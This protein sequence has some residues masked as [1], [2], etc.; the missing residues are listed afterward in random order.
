MSRASAFLAVAAGAVA[1]AC[2]DGV[3]TASGGD[4][5]PIVAA[6]EFVAG[7]D[8][9]LWSGRSS[10]EPLVVRVTDR[11]GAPVAD[12]VVRFRID[13]VGARLSQ[14]RALTGPDG[15]AETFLLDLT[16]GTARI[17]ASIADVEDIVELPVRPAP[18][19]IRF[20]GGTGE[21]GVPG[22]PHPDSLIQVEVLDTEGRPLP[23][24]EVWFTA[25]GELASYRDT[26]DAEGRTSTILRRT[27]FGAGP[28][29]VT[30]FILGFP[31]VTARTQRP[32]EPVARRVVVV[33]IDGLRGD[34]LERWVPPT[35][36]RL[37]RE[38]AGTARATSVVP[39]LTVPAHLSLMA[40]VPPE[41][42]GVFSDDLE[43]TRQMASLDPLFRLARDRGR[44]AVAFM[45]DRG[46]LAGFE[47]ALQCRQAFGLDSLSLTEPTGLQ[48]V[49][50][51]GPA[52]A[53]PE[54]ELAFVHIPDPDLAGHEHG[55]ESDEYGEAVLR[56][57]SALARG[58][59]AATSDSTL[60]IVVSDHGGGGA[61][62][63]F[64][65]GSAAPEDVRVPLLLDGSG[66][67]SGELG[68][69]SILDVAPTALWALGLV[70]P[71][72]Y[73][74]RVLLEAFRRNPAAAVG[75]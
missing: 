2:S 51:A 38:G 40:G 9:E 58:L 70:P 62:G 57:D 23:D 72:E 73:E 48:A 32:L 18:G 28:G 37:A 35:L 16:P 71:G 15:R 61:F 4:G 8:Q 6:V 74:G 56:A 55:F 10:P 36:Q 75:M 3:P 67:V 63:R 69:A 19:E 5:V 66:V 65:H 12:T 11:A 53:D 64:Q 42:H 45:S 25:P 41:E 33:S 14:G 1:A 44:R 59:E 26:T 7:T 60:V 31:G 29:P 30:A 49:E 17:R 68:E 47:E 22:F 20:L 39:T 52:L 50:S 43:F 27:R 46:P 13:G 21:A 34:A 24:T 54:V